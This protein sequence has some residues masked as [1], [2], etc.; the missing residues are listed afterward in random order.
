MKTLIL[1]VDDE[2]YLADLVATIL[3][4]E[5]YRVVVA[6]DGLTAFET[7]LRTQPDLIVSDVQMPHLDGMSLL[8]R[9][10]SVGYAAPIILMSAVYLY[11]D[12]IVAHFIPKP[13]DID[14]LLGAVRTALADNA[15]GP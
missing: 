6:Y 12:G 9:L 4:E 10:R 1:V 7:A 13:F 14:Q 3:E 11:G 15:Q 5:G 2:G 8:R